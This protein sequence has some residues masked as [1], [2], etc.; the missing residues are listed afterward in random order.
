MQ[1]THSG[2]SD[3]A[4]SAL[5]KNSLDRRLRALQLKLSADAILDIA[6]SSPLW[7][8]IMA[9]LFGGFVREL[10][11]TPLGET[12]PWILL[13]AAIGAAVLFVWRLV[14]RRAAEGALEGKAWRWLIA[15]AYLLVATSWC[16]VTVLF[17][18]PKNI[19]NH[20][21]LLVVAIAAVSLFLSSRSGDFLMVLAATIPNL[22]MI[23]AYFLRHDLWFDSVISVLLPIWAVQLHLDAWRGCRTVATA[24]RTKLEME[25]LVAELEVAR[26]EA[27]RANRAKS[28]F[29]ANMSHELRTPLNAILGFSEIILTEAFGHDAPRYK[30]YVA[31]IAKS[32]RHL[33]GLI[34]DVLD[35]AKIE[36]EKLELDREWLDAAK[37][38]GECTSI[39]LDRA[40]RSGVAL[41]SSVSPSGL[42]VFCDDRA[43]RQILLNLLSNALKFTPKGG[44]I[45]VSLVGEKTGVEL[46]VRDTGCG[47]PEDQLARL[48]QPFEQLDNRYGRANGGTGLG[49][50]LVRALSELHG[51]KCRVE[52]ALGKGTTVTISLP[53][54][55]SLAP[56]EPRT[57]NEAA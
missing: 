9:G 8:F 19:A 31:D 6:L 28:V 32:G 37:L 20:S 16:L 3:K 4:Q 39:F 18:E 36:A 21:F 15:A 13:C 2:L 33:L 43:F 7:A 41:A 48:F 14:K 1:G 57:A 12:W 51:G 5:S 55:E 50:T 27:A 30:D 47:I 38:I 44:R 10:G 52:S 24:H 23:W 53:Y 54:T 42:R 49:L 56:A 40:E 29:L 34:D 22:A 45:E 46:S 35:I 26:D 25:S 17:W 11:H